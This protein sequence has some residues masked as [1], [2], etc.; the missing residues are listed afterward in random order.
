M[1]LEITTPVTTIEGFTA[2]TSYGRV[3][4]IDR[5][6]GTSLDCTVTLYLDEASYLAG[7][8]YLNVMEINF[9][10]NAPYNREIQ[11]VDTLDLAHD[12]LITSLGAQ[13][14]S[15]VKLLA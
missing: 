10:V 13:S 14:I 3:S 12:F 11:G 5:Q 6:A 1:A 4:V 7:A 15:A 2:P 8:Q 9:T